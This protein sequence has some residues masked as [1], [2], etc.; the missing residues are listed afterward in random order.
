MD[1]NFPLARRPTARGRRGDRRFPLSGFQLFFPQH[2]SAVGRVVD[3]EVEGGGEQLGEAFEV[4]SA[5]TAA[6]AERGEGGIGEDDALAGAALEFEDE[7]GEGRA[8]EAQ[9]RGLPR[10]GAGDFVGGGR[11]DD[12][13]ARR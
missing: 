1:E 9:E 8:A 6:D 7:F 11:R 13:G 12:D 5:E 3:F 2:Q 10:E 4:V